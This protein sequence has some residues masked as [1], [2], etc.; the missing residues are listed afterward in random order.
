M[1]NNRYYD[2]NRITVITHHLQHTVSA[3]NDHQQSLGIIYRPWAQDPPQHI[4]TIF[5]REVIMCSGCIIGFYGDLYASVLNEDVFGIIERTW[6]SHRSRY[7]NC[8]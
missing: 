7:R 4:W 8:S 2:F 1:N 3:T 5:S 6:Y